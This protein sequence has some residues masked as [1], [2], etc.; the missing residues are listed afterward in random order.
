MIVYKR[1]QRKLAPPQRDIGGK[2]VGAG[3]LPAPLN[4]LLA[5]ALVYGR[6]K[7]ALFPAV[8][9]EGP[10]VHC[11]GTVRIYEILRPLPGREPRVGPYGHIGQRVRRHGKGRAGLRTLTQGISAGEGDGVD[12]RGTLAARAAQDAKAGLNLVLFRVEPEVKAFGLQARRGGVFALALRLEPGAKLG[13]ER[14]NGIAR[15]GRSV[16]FI[17]QAGLCQRVRVKR[18]LL[19]IRYQQQAV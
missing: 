11:V 15:F 1:A 14:R 12:K 18:W 19:G 9:S 7:R 5:R 3:G 10:Y 8:R 4:G 2:A 13:R 16:A 17:H 6:M